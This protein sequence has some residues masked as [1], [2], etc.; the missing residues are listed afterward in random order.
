MHANSIR[1]GRHAKAVRAMTTSLRILTAL[2]G[3]VILA[4]GVLLLSR[5]GHVPTAFRTFRG[6]PAELRS[7]AQVVAG[8][9]HGSAPAVIQMG[10][11]LLIATPVLRVLFVGIGFAMERD[12]L[13]VAVAGVVLTVL[14]AGLVK[15]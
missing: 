5:A 8:A 2:A 4:G 9:F 6:E 15:Q 13:Y 10:I 3:L 11:L 12:W 7:V 14:L 1:A